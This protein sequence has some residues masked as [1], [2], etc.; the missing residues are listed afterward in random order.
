VAAEPQALTPPGTPV[1]GPDLPQSGEPIPTYPTS[2]PQPFMQVYELRRGALIGRGELSF[3]P[4]G[5]AYEARLTTSL[6]DVKWLE[7]ISRGGFDAAGIAPLRFTDQRRGRAAKAANFQRL[8]SDEGATISYSG[9]AVRHAL[10][11]GAQDRLSWIVQLSAIAQGGITLS[12]G[13]S[14]VMLVSGARGDADLWVFTVVGPERV[15]T[16]GGSVESVKLVRAPRRPYDT[17]AEIWL[18]PARAHLPAKLR[19]SPTPRGDALE[20]VLQ[21]TTTAARP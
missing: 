3:Q 2:I 11:A 12:G 21:Q 18:D 15:D 14:I 1:P 19:L 7:W 20:F 5:D 6:G 10:H 13:A 8:G 4:A 16:A 9:P 17:M